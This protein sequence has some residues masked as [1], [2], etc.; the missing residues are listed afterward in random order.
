[1]VIE[2][3][4][5]T[6][7]AAVTAAFGLVL[8]VL[9]AETRAQGARGQSN[10]AALA[11]G[12]EN[13]L[14]ALGEAESGW[15]ATTSWLEE[16]WGW[17]ENLSTY[18]FRSG[19]AASMM[20]A[21]GNGVDSVLAYLDPSGVLP[22]FN[23][24][25]YRLLLVRPVHGKQTSEYGFRK[26]PIHG[27]IRYHKGIDFRADRGTP[28]RAAAPGVVKLA[29]RWQGYGNCVVID[30]G[31]GVETRYAHLSRFRVSE[32][33]FVATNALIALS[34]ATGRVTGPHLHFEVRQDGRPVDP[35]R[36]FVGGVAPAPEPANLRELLRLWLTRA[37]FGE[38]LKPDA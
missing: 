9:P 31:L 8:T 5:R 29:R 23:L 10:S 12:L 18:E 36:A 16:Q 6:R 11:A 15:H 25:T 22:R 3:Q 13:A 32:G 21:F 4:R 2:L 27:L 28:V 38:S 26:D 20:R 7:A 19:M 30:H 17:L 37:E 24:Q 35:E 1:M 34:G 14:T 33:D